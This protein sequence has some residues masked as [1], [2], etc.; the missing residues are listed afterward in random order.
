[1]PQVQP[2]KGKKLVIRLACKELGIY[3]Y[4]PYIKTK[5]K[6]K[7]NSFYIQQRTEVIGQN[8]DQLEKQP[9]AFRES[10]FTRA[11]AWGRNRGRKNLSAID[12]LLETQ[13]GQV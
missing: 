11:A 6:P 5:T 2:Q 3:R 1:M 12:D 9:G 7:N 13:C 10:Q 4:R 8:S